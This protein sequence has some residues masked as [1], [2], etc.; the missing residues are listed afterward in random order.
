MKKSFLLV[1]EALLMLL[2]SVTGLLVP[3][4]AKYIMAHRDLVLEELE[5]RAMEKAEETETEFDD[6]LYEKFFDALEYLS[7]FFKDKK[8]PK[9]MA[10]AVLAEEEVEEEKA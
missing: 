4:F 8:E 1:L 10:D 6:E 7:I 5:K 9:T 2:K 3:M